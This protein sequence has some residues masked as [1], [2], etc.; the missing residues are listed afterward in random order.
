MD[1]KPIGKMYMNTRW[2]Q[3]TEVV[4]IPKKDAQSSNVTNRATQDDFQGNLEAFYE[5]VLK[6]VSSQLQS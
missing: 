4:N 2:Y 3:H 1:L 5:I 6:L